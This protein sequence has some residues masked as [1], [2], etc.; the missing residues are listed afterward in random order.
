[1][2]TTTVKIGPEID[3]E[4]YTEFSNAAKANGQSFRLFGKS[5]EELSSAR[6]RLFSKCRETG[7]DG[8]LSPFYR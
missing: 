7:S 4:L 3:K 5:D 2:A 6:T 1:M 8:S